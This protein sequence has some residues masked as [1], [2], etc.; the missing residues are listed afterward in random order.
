MDNRNMIG[1]ITQWD[2]EGGGLILVMSQA[3]KQEE[4]SYNYHSQVLKDFPLYS[5]AAPKHTIKIVLT[6]GTASVLVTLFNTTFSS[7][8]SLPIQD[9]SLPEVSSP[10]MKE[11]IIS[12]PITPTILNL[13]NGPHLV[14]YLLGIPGLDQ[15]TLVALGLAC[16]GA[17]P[18][19]QV[20]FKSTEYYD[21]VVVPCI[22]YYFLSAANSATFL[23]LTFV[24]PALVHHQMIL[25]L[26][27]HK[28]LSLCSAVSNHREKFLAYLQW[29]YLLLSLVSDN[30]RDS[31]ISQ[32]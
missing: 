4:I 28:I 19:L 29:V 5:L 31:I 18:N 11:D 8:P 14:Y 7:P 32:A 10:L 27:V 2:G 30:Q 6:T 17:V 1:L 16:E 3:P 22:L 23:V 24:Q 13:A 25:G 9:L 20:Q 12:L 15:I 26:H 21:M